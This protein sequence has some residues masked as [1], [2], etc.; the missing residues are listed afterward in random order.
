MST[1]ERRNQIFFKVKYSSTDKTRKTNEKG[2]RPTI[3]DTYDN[4]ERKKIRTEISG[5]P[6]FGR[7]L[8][9][10]FTTVSVPLRHQTRG[11]LTTT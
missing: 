5:Y 8:L 10:E 11:N 1:V 4:N 7:Q 3:Q 6:I 2:E 9:R